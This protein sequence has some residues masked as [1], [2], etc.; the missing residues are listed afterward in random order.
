MS[1]AATAKVRSAKKKKTTQAAALADD[2]DQFDVASIAAVRY[3]SVMDATHCL[4]AWKHFPDETDLD[5]EPLANVQ[6]TADE[7]LDAARKHLA[8]ACAP[9]WRWEYYLARPQDDKKA[10]GWYPYDVAAQAK[11][12][13]TFRAYCADRD[14][15]ARVVLV[16]SGRYTY[17]V[18]FDAMLQTNTLVTD[19]TVRPIRCRLL[20]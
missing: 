3:S 9:G 1:A 17:L 7:Y 2:D 8:D 10:A 18:D 16:P 11:L 19:Q 20:Q 6:G 13:A 15:A 12:D 5:W 4:V 14:T